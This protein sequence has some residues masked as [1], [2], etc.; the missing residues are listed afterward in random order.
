MK[1]KLLFKHVYV[2]SLFLQLFTISSLKE[3]PYMTFKFS[4]FLENNHI[5]LVEGTP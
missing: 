5:F 2:T 1:L 3:P 4:Q